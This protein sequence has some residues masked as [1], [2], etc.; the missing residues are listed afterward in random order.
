MEF[1]A[2]VVLFM[3]LG[4]LLPL[5]TSLRRAWQIIA[6][7]LATTAFIELVQLMIPGRVTSWSD[8]ATNTIGTALGWRSSPSPVAQLRLRRL[9]PKRRGHEQNERSSCWGWS[10]RRCDRRAGRVSRC[11]ARCKGS[12]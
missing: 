10:G 5:T 8:V 2:N 7:G 12:R 11:P 1:F 9:R 6:I 3:P 4:A